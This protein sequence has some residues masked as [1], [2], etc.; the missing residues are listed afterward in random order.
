MREN[1]PE[2]APTASSTTPPT[3]ISMAAASIAWLGTASRWLRT[4]PKPQ[5]AAAPSTMITPEMRPDAVPSPTRMITPPS[6]TARATAERKV[7]R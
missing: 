5:A 7:T 6:P 3:S 4:D 1:S 2:P